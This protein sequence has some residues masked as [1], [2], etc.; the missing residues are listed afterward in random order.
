MDNEGVKGAMYIAPFLC[1]YICVCLF[2]FDPTSS[3]L[4]SDLASKILSG[5]M[6][7]SVLSD[8]SVFC[9]QCYLFSV[10][11]VFSV[12]CFQC[13]M[14]SVLS[15]IDI[16]VSGIIICSLKWLDICQSCIKL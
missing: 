2:Y 6:M 10:F 11:S 14:F 8:F 15:V 12:I 3:V 16:F 7:F 9:F 13:Y 5:D 4:F 1:I